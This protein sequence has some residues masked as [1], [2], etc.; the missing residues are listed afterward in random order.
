MHTC[1]FFCR[2]ISRGVAMRFFR[3]LPRSI[4]VVAMNGLKYELKVEKRGD[5]IFI[6]EG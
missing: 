6:T 4:I 5:S 2:D 1:I 3:K